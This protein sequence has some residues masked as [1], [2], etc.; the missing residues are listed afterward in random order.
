M[1]TRAISTRGWM[2]VL[3]LVAT[4]TGCNGFIDDYRSRDFS[5]QTA[6][7][8]GPDPIEV[9]SESQDGD[10][11]A[12]AYRALADRDFAAMSAQEQEHMIKLL[13][14][15]AS[16]ERQVLARIA[17]VDTLGTIED[18]RA[19]AG[20]KDAYYRA[21]GFRPE[22]GAM[23]KCRILDALGNTHHPDAI[24]LL[25]RVLREPPLEG[26]TLDKQH[27][28]DERIAAARALGKFPQTQAVQPL[29]QTLQADSDVALRNC[30]HE[31][32]QEITGED[33]IPADAQAWAEHL[34]STTYQEDPFPKRKGLGERIQTVVPVG[35][36]GKDQ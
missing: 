11:R 22:V 17:A 3:A 35:G 13:S 10:R 6:M 16:Q 25:V 18:P 28:T 1:R 32:L 19:A 2:K 8:N 12:R 26:S 24:E 29:L 30:A 7:G 34:K 33:D 31:S 15:G 27:K 23:L 5:W 36:V 14:S 21:G 9:L 20:L 4:L